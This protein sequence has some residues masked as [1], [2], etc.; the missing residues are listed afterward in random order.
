MAVRGSY[1]WLVVAASV[2]ASCSGATMLP[3]ARQV[4]VAASPPGPGWNEVTILE[5]VDG[6]GCGPLGF[7]GHREPAV[8]RL[9]NLTVQ[10][11]GQWLQILEEHP[12]GEEPVCGGYDFRYVIRGMAWS[13]AH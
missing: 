8:E 12:P 1:A 10:V 6:V 2:L 11:G 4:A 13:R 5:G 3:G 9:R 7:R